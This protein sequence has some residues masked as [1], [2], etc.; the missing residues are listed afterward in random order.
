MSLGSTPRAIAWRMIDMQPLISA[1]LATMLA[2]VATTIM[3]QNAGVGTDIQ[4]GSE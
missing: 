2:S 1:W 4:K 3:G